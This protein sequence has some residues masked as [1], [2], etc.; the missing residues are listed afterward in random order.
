MYLSCE[1]VLSLHRIPLTPKVK[2]QH[3]IGDNSYRNHPYDASYW[4]LIVVIKN[5]RSN[6]I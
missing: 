2:G 1:V 5:V 6:Q 3:E 4:A